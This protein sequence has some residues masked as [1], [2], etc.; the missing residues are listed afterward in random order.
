[1]WK[2]MVWEFVASELLIESMSWLLKRRLRA[3]SARFFRS[4]MEMFELLAAGRAS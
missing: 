4:I 1:M 3:K 2:I